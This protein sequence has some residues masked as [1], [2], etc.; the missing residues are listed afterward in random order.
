MP[1][2]PEVQ[3]I[4]SQLNQK[5]LKRTFVDIWTDAPRLIKSGTP[6]ALKKF[7]KGEKIIEVKRLGKNIL[8][9]LDHQKI[10]LIHL[11]LTGQ[12]LLGQWIKSKEGWK[13]ANVDKPQKFIHLVLF[14]NKEALAFSDVRKFGKIEFFLEKDLANKTELQLGPDPISPN[15][16]FPVFKKAIL[17]KKS[18]KVKQ[19][20]LDQFVVAGIGNI[21]SDEILWTA[22]IH[23][24][25]NINSLKT[26]DLKR[27]YEATKRI[28]N[29]AVKLRGDSFSD[30][31]D[32]FGGMGGYDKVKKVYQRDGQACY[33]CQTKIQSLKVGGRTARFCPKCQK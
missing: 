14:L 1:E 29:L 17:G 19:V 21:Y 8:F 13:E 6:A 31:R 5:V 18:G 16:T 12:L 2:L 7:L 30:Y 32:L 25:T 3:T 33:V 28:L 23:P 10:L 20:L 15:F 22:K 26:A 9:Y 24:L 27:L 4:V 11:K